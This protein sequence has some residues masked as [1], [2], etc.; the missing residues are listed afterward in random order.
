MKG[1]RIFLIWNG[2]VDEALHIVQRLK[3]L[4][5]R[6]VYLILNGTKEYEFPGIVLHLDDQAKKGIPA[7]GLDAS[8][9]P[10]PDA[11]LIKSMYRCES[12]ILTMM[13]RKVDSPDNP[14]V[15]DEKKHFYYHLLQYW[16][17]VLEQF[18]P[19]LIVFPAVPHNVSNFTLYSLAK[20]LGIQTMLFQETWASD[21]LMLQLDYDQE[22]PLL[23]EALKKNEGKSF[24]SEDLSPD[25]KDYYMNHTGSGK[26]T[27]P[28]DVIFFAGEYKG[29]KRLFLKIQAVKGGV[30]D[31]TFFL[32]LYKRLLRLFKSDLKKDYI[33]LAVVPELGKP[34]IY[35]PLHWQ[36]EC[37]TSPLGDMY[38][39]QLLMLETL[40]ASLPAGWVI[41]VK[42]HPFQWSVSGATSYSNMR[43][44]GYY[45]HVSRLKNVFL[46]PIST[47]TYA[48]SAHSRA[49]AT[50]T[51][52]A[53]IEA[54]LRG[55]PALI[56]GYP[57]YMSLSGIFRIR[58]KEDCVQ[59]LLKIGSGYKPDHK[60][61]LNYLKSFDESTGRGYLEPMGKMNTTKSRDESLSEVLRLL[62]IGMKICDYR[63]HLGSHKA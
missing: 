12:L 50:V 2:S 13:N 16:R 42:E 57:W 33:R 46:V 11:E 3:N 56:F 29:L 31:G 32:K 25:M 27:T 41:Y 9:F 14:M 19:D 63:T 1:K 62:E 7:R 24:T 4:S 15:L 44:K 53:G 49:V 43:Y 59:A 37:T 45:E 58:G 51:G 35:V 22:S 28:F 38:V 61:V 18:K 8:S 20:H 6:V 10:P 26:D 55:K 21:R 34:Y 30:M 52:R 23:K 48:L 40:A 36:P 54:V 5:H 39:D 60:S 47:D 17:G